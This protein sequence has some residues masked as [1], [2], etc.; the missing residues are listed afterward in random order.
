MDVL[1]LMRAG[2]VIELEFRAP[3]SAIGE[4]AGHHGQLAS[5]HRDRDVALHAGHRVLGFPDVAKHCML[6]SFHQASENFE[7]LFNKKKYD[8]LSP[9]LK[10]IIDYAVQAS[11][12]AMSCVLWPRRAGAFA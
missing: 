10:S 1:D 11:S 6:Q 7:I 5:P 3:P 2:P 9:E 8:A 12:A 4:L